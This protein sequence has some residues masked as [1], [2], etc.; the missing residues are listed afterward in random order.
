MLLGCDSMVALPNSTRGRQM[1]FAKNSDRPAEECQPLVQLDR[2]QYPPGT[3]AECQFL[4]LPQADVTY[5]HVGS[6]PWWCWGYEHGFN[7][8]QVVIGNEALA[9]RFPEFQEPKLIGMDLNRLGLERG[10]TAAE[11]V[12][13]ITSVVSKYGQ[14]LVRNDLGVR[15]Y[16][17]GFIVADPAEA[18]VIETA[19]HEWVVKGVE[20]ALGI[21]NVHSIR[22]DWDRLSPTAESRAVENGWWQADS[23]RFD[24]AG[25]YC[26]FAAAEPGRGVYRRARS[27]GVMDRERG[28]ID[29]R[30][31]ISTLSD[32]ADGTS[33]GEPFQSEITLPRSICMHY[34]GEG[35]GNTAASLVADLCSDGS[36]LPVY[37]CSLYS[38]CLGIFLPTFIEGEVPSVL[39]VGGENPSD[40]SP[41]WLFRKLGN[42]VKNDMKF[43]PGLVSAIRAEWAGFQEE[44]LESAYDM[45]AGAQ[46][47]IAEGQADQ[48]SRRLT[49]YM[50]LN[51]DRAL[52]T[53]RELVS[54]QSVAATPS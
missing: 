13:V 53:V 47:L 30:T 20:T 50:R 39:A 8:H 2:S 11:A 12:D 49:E 3:N 28:A 38:P 31:M 36:R 15:T 44:L 29:V 37:W 19:G 21:S 17:N 43:D 9:S 32:H 24:F 46:R 16:D 27:C 6:R 35:T 1:L 25:A 45:A 40:D 48:A 4:E 33:P 41:W 14:G 7:E 22:T 18:Y 42:I 52:K 51:T 34:W 26:D 10:R 54:R 5:R 23:G